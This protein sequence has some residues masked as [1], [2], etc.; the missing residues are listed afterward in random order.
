[1]SLVEDYGGRSV[2][3]SSSGVTEVE[4]KATDAKEFELGSVDKLKFGIDGEEKN[5]L[6]D[7]IRDSAI[8]SSGTNFR[9]LKHRL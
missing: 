2:K 3:I 9:R 8:F 6:K 7:L 1:M 5:K 4:V